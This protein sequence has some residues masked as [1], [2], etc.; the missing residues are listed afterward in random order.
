MKTEIDPHRSYEVIE[1]K[2][3]NQ[4]ISNNAAW[5]LGELTLNFG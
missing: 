1:L 4:A 5:A 3:L 2:I